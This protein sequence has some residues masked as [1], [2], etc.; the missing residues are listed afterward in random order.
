MVTSWSTD[1]SQLTVVP[2][3]QR[4][5]GVSWAHQD[6]STTQSEFVIL[7]FTRCASSVREVFVIDGHMTD[8][9]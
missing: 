3:A 1:F 4:P 9:A 2:R 5:V 7:I 8:R 6:G